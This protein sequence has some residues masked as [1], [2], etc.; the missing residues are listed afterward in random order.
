MRSIIAASQDAHPDAEQE[1]SSMTK[2]SQARSSGG[3]TWL[4]APVA[5]FTL[6]AGLFAVALRSGDPSRLPSMLIGKPVPAF[7]FPAVEGLGDAAPSV[8]GFD[9]SALA[10][11]NVSVVNFF[12]SWCAPCVEEHPQLSQL[13]DTPGVTLVGVNV[14]DEPAAV[15][16]FL[17]RYGSPYAILGADRAG[18]GSIEWGLTGTPET[19]I[20]DGRG[21]VRMKYIGPVMPEV[22]T[23][24]ILPAIEAAKKPAP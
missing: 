13:R 11:G 12:A 7:A 20:V 1:P 4:I 19:F 18:R 22:L 24:V 17:N 6:L 10:Q 15:R 14:K 9:A 2:S 8:N 23:R 16:Q 3:R 5:I 21:I